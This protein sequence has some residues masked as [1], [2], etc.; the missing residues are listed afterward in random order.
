MIC[1]DEYDRLWFYLGRWP[2]KPG[3][4]RRLPGGGTRPDFQ[5]VLL[6]GFHFTGGKKLTFKGT[7][8]SQTGEWEGVPPGFFRRLPEASDSGWAA[9]AIVP[10][11]PVSFTKA[12]LDQFE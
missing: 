5:V 10:P 11:H 9:G 2:G 12:Q 8:V 6:R 1:F 4:Q 3:T 7:D